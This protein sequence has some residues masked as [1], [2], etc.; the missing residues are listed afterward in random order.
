MDSRDNI[1]PLSFI[2]THIHTLGTSG[3][4]QIFILN[5][6]PSMSPFLGVILFVPVNGIF[7]MAFPSAGR[8][9]DTLAV[10]VKVIYLSALG[11]P[12]SVFV[13][14]SHC[15]HDVAMGIVSGWIWVMDCKITT[16]SLGHKI[17]IAVF[18]YHLRTHFKRHFSWQ[19][20]NE[21]PCKL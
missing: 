21:T 14:G 18:L 2:G 9:L 12:L 11:H 7:L 20:N 13:N 16:H 15:Q 17:L 10:L 1:K 4:L 8:E 3:K 5:D 6:F 19:G